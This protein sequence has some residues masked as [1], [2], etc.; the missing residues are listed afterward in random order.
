MAA[1]DLVICRAGALTISELIELSKPSVLIPYN[2][3]KVGQYENAVMLEEREGALLFDNNE[4]D[5]AV[6]TA[7]EL[8][9]NDE[10]LRRMKLRIKAL[11]NANATESIINSLDIWRN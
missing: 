1:A 4:A 6:R 11:R 2:S 10:Q 3:V 8:I 7:I 5:E 9:K